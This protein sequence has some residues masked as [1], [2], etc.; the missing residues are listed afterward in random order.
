MFH[1]MILTRCVV[2]RWTICLHRENRRSVNLFA[3]KT[4]SKVSMG[5]PNTGHPVRI[6]LIAANCYR[7]ESLNSIVFF[8][9]DDSRNHSNMIA[10]L[11]FASYPDLLYKST[12]EFRAAIGAQKRELGGSIIEAANEP[13]FIIVSWF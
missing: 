5:G 6:G 7:E 13:T 11:L 1:V 10:R 9:T 2:A 12:D 8:I 3:G 4:L